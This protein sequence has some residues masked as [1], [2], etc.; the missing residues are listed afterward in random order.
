MSLYFYKFFKMIIHKLIPIFA[1]IAFISI[2]VNGQPSLK[3]CEVYMVNSAAIDITWPLELK[4]DFE[5][6]EVKKA[7]YLKNTTV[8]TGKCKNKLPLYFEKPLEL[9]IKEAI[10]AETTSTSNQK[11]DLFINDFDIVDYYLLNGKQQVMRL[12]LDFFITQKGKP[13][14]I[15]ST[16]YSIFLKED[17][18]IET[19]LSEL[20]KLSMLDFYASRQTNNT[21]TYL[22]NSKIVEPEVDE[23]AHL[24]KIGIYT[25]INDMKTNKPSLPLNF[26]VF[27]SLSNS[28]R[29]Y[30]KDKA[31][32]NT[33][34]Q[35]F[36]F[37]FSDGKAI[38]LN[39]GKFYKANHF[40][41]LKAIEGDY[42]LFED[43]VF[44]ENLNND[45]FY[46]S[47][48]TTQGL[49]FG[50]ISIMF[51]NSLTDKKNKVIFDMN[52]GE[53]FTITK[54]NFKSAVEKDRSLHNLYKKIPA[55]TEDNQLKFIEEMI[56]RNKFV[57]TETEL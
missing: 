51:D 36:V 57:L 1:F 14:K 33:Y 55:K 42:F 21:L 45:A 49:A 39:A 17:G 15:Y 56:K 37:G 22:D 30:L 26:N 44:E 20:A 28:G 5:I 38:Y 16:N 46:K 41:K 52:D 23:V 31:S 3:S 50:T 13:N 32:G 54:S 7:S 9:T 24:Y 27:T 19:P 25:S 40:V 34:N 29:F 43:V 48:E 8:K 10:N 11:I 6:D 35:P 2:S 53:I 47:S 12:G 18:F 4:V